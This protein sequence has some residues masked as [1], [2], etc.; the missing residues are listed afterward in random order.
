MNGDARPRELEPEVGLEVIGEIM[1]LF[2]RRILRYREMK[3][4]EPV[5]S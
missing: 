4:D 1:C 2:D 3:V 5:R